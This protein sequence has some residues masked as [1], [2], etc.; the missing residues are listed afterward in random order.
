LGTIL[1][2]LTFFY[3]ERKEKKEEQLWEAM[4]TA[5]AATPTA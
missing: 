3:N 5:P 4:G 1:V 2:T